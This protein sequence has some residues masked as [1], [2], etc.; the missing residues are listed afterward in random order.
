DQPVAP[1]QGEKQPDSEVSTA[2]ETDTHGNAKSIT[3]A[4]RASRGVTDSEVKSISRELFSRTG[5]SAYF[6]HVAH[7]TEQVA[8]ALD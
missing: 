4:Q 1:N 2:S 6:Q 8:E 7:L 3:V 5:H